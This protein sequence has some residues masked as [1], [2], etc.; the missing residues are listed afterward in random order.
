MLV[1]EFKAYAKPDQFVA[2]NEAIRICQFIRNKSIRLWID[3]N[4]KSWFDLS[5]YCAIWAK[6]FDFANKLG[7]MARQASAERAWA[8]ISRFYENVKKGIKGKKVGFPTFQKDCRSVA[9]RG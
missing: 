7:A 6:E 1:L 3:G 4:V 8:S 9:F 2:I 5:K